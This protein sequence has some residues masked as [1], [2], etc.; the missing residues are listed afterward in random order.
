MT[1]V[2]A[3]AAKNISTAVENNGNL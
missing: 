3:A 1:P 2:H